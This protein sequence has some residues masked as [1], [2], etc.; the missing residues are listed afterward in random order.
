MNLPDFFPLE[1]PCTLHFKV[2]AGHQKTEISGILDDRTIK[3]SV[4]AIPE[5]GKANAEIIKFFKKKLGLQATILSGD[6]S[7]RKR[8]FLEKS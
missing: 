1:F 5:K 8:I 6:T 2:R 3:L 4:K 7:N